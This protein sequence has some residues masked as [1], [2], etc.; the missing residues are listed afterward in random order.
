MPASPKHP[1][2]RAPRRSAAVRMRRFPRPGAARMKPASFALILSRLMA[3]SAGHRWLIPV[4]VALG[5]TAFLFEGIGIYL[6]MPLLQTLGGEGAAGDSPNPLI[7]FVTSRTEGLAPDTK[8]VV[9]VSA[10]V[11]CIL[12]KGITTLLSQIAYSY[13]GARF[14]HGVRQETFRAILRADQAFLD[15]QPPGALL[16]TLATETWR[17]SQGL[18]AL[19]YLILNGC[20]VVIFL[21]LMLVLSWKTTLAVGLG[22]AVILGIV[23]LVTAPARQ[24]GEAAVRANQ[25]LASRISEGLAGQRTI[26]LFARESD[27]IGRFAQASDAVRRQFL[28]LE[29]INAVPG[30][31]LEVLFA[32][33]LGALLISSHGV[34][35]LSSLIVFLALLLRLQPHAAALMHARVAILTLGG[36]LDNVIATGEGAAR[37]SVVSGELPAPAPRREIALNDVSFRYPGAEENVLSHAGFVMPALST[38]AIV[39]PS[40]AGKSTIL[41]LICRLGDPTGGAVL[42]DGQDLRSFDLASWRRRIAVVPQ[43]V[44]LFNTTIRQNIAY[45]RPD[46]SEDEIRAAARAAYAD[47]FI[48][49]QPQGYDTVVGDRGVRFSGGQ[50]QRMALARAFLAGPDILI[51]DEAT[52]AL[53]GNSERFV[54]DALREQSGRFT[55]IVVAH[56][57]SSIDTADHV[58]VLDHGRVAE[59]GAPGDLMT[60]GGL[61]AEMFARERLSA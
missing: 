32:V 4:L 54:Q 16:N 26:R 45:G 20:A 12:M 59:T 58:V 51:L 60:R 50:R 28:R 44:F 15:R 39:G 6:L 23:Q 42:V 57:L 53:D 3:V 55:V 21:A 25:E 22:V 31:L 27:E 49:A 18:Q 43:D 13:A 47:D 37:Q 41:N 7:G 48:I 11:F 19:S 17:L 38:T 14:G 24:V 10:I 35:G 46:A 5:L 8:V 33:L 36:A 30:P 29:A 2:G 1:V 61:F 34:G 40:G 9:L 56:R 52:N